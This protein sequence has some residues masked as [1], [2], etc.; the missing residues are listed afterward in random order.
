MESLRHPPKPR[1]GDRVAVVSPSAGLPA[2]FPHV[3]EL[4]LRRLLVPAMAVGRR[5]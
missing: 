4:G 2:V 1:P 3:Y 5:R